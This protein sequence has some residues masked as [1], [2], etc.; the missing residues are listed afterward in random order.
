MDGKQQLPCHFLFGRYL[1][2]PR[3]GGG[4][5][6]RMRGASAHGRRA[7]SHAKRAL[8]QSRTSKVPPD[9]RREPARRAPRYTLGRCRGVRRGRLFARRLRGERGLP[10]PNA[11]EKIDDRDNEGHR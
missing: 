11:G 2:G 4:N 9:R 3:G 10:R 5:R 7:V 6:A 8:Q 1:K